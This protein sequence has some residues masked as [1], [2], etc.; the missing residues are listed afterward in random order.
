MYCDI[1]KWNFVFKGVINEKDTSIKLIKNSLKNRTFNRFIKNVKIKQSSCERLRKS[2][3][4]R[5][6]KF[7]YIAD[8]YEYYDNF[9]NFNFE[10]SLS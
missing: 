7:K 9:G 6:F 1:K 4:L 5:E 3:C 2:K 10:S 8:F